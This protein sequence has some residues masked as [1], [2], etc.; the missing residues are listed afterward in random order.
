MRVEEH[1]MKLGVSLPLSDIGGDPATV[2]LFAQAAEAAGYDHLAAPDHVL[3]VNVASRPEWGARTTSADLF[4]DPFVLFGFLSS[5]TTWIGFSTQVLILPQRQSVLVAKQAA[6]LDVLSGGRFRLGIGI[7]WNE[8]EFVGLNEDFHNRGRRS[9]EQVR[10]MQALWAEPHV[11][12]E[13]QWHRIEDA[14]INPL[15]IG[16]R[17]PIW[18]G[19]HHDLTLRRIAK[20]GDGWMMNAHPAAAAAEADFAKLRAYAEQ[21]GRDPASIG[22]EV[23]VS[24]GAGDEASWREEF[25]F[26]KSAGVTHVTVNSAF[27]RNHHRRIASR[28]LQAHLTALERYRDA[29]ADLL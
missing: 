26:W 10:V 12:F 25:K 9:E 7:G 14:G 15:P 27:E 1:A 2:K 6:C 28:S 5:C 8:V 13:G 23:W 22:V 4:H 20:W 11:K 24:T 17:I 16:R 21:A 3:G 29:V 18:F 19:G